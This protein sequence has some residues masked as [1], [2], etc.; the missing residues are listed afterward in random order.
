MA[1][2]TEVPTNYSIYSD[3]GTVP[4]GLA[5]DF[6]SRLNGYAGTIEDKAQLEQAWAEKML[7]TLGYGAIGGGT[8]AAG[9]GL[10]VT[11]TAATAI[12]GNYVRTDA[13]STVSVTQST[14]NY[15]FMRQNGAFTAN[16]TGAIPGTTDNNGTAL[17]WGSCVTDSTAVTSVSNSRVYFGSAV[18]TN[19]GA[20]IYDIGWFVAGTPTDAQVVLLYSSPRA[21]IIPSSMT[22][23]IGRAGSA[24]TGTVHFQVQHN[25]T[26]VGSVTFTAAS[27]ASFSLTS[28]IALTSGD[29]LKVV[30]PSPADSTL[31][32][33]SVTFSATY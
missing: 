18:R 27:T 11:I 28:A 32:N 15:I 9:A 21:V 4:A 30:A 20:N 23:S 19:A 25:G 5:S 3:A 8:I 17:L 14:T 22:G 2:V 16:T 12:V 10:N 33:V 1:L 26:A 31:Q 29:T 13:S 6:R 7:Q 24:S